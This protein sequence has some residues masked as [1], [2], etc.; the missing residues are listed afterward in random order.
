MAASIRLALHLWIWN[1]LL[2]GN[3]I[4]PQTA[5]AVVGGTPF[6]QLGKV[7]EVFPPPA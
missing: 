1:G 7:V 6:R 4:V 5:V 3:E 2:S